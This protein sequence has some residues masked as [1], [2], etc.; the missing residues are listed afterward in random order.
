[1][2]PCYQVD[3]RG[4]SGRNRGILHFMQRL[5]RG[6]QAYPEEVDVPYYGYMGNPFAQSEMAKGCAYRP[7]PYEVGLTLLPLLQPFNKGN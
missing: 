1:M 3:Y 7:E 6:S 5:G 2:L 4:R